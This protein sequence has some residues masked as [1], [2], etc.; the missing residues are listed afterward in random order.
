MLQPISKSPFADLLK[1]AGVPILDFKDTGGTWPAIQLD[2]I[3]EYQEF[4]KSVAVYPRE[5]RD[6]ALTYLALGLAGEAGEVANKVKK[7][8]RG[9]HLVGFEESVVDELGDVL[10]YLARM[11]DELG[12]RLS[13]VALRNQSKL[14]DRQARGVL[15]GSGDTR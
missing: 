13:D 10:W 4:T 2:P 9:D 6:R 1:E 14:Q 11:A 3:D 8:V 5:D 7:Q 12:I 15:K